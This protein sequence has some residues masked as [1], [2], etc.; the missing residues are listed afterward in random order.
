MKILMMKRN[1]IQKTILITI[2]FS[3]AAAEGFSQLKKDPL[4]EDQSPLHLALGIS[5]NEVRKSKEDSTYISHKLYYRTASG[6]NDSIKIDIKGRGNF[7]LRECDFPPLW[8]KIKS[9]QAKGTVFQGNKKLKLVLPCN[10]Q[11]GNNELIAKEWLCYKLYEAIT[12]HTFRTRLVNVDLTE[13]RRKKENTYQLKG[14]LIEDIDKIAKRMDGKPVEATRVDA[15]GLQDTASFRFSLFQLM[16]SNTDWSEI[17]Q[18]N[19]KLIQNHSGYI[20]VPYDFDMSGLVDAPYS[21]VSVIGDTQLPIESVRERYFRG[22]CRSTE[23]MQYVRNEFLTKE[24]K[25]LS[26]PDLLKNELPARDVTDIKNYLEDFFTILK[27]NDSFDD[28]VNKRCRI[29]E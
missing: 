21:V 8:I 9:S 7:R 1:N 16:I 5:I 22:Y 26:L 18:H 27:S 24:K 12:D 19:N 6:V 11:R 14:I 20:P 25:I 13:K 3:L 23:V 28:H 4:F 29:L 2:L 17:F 10:D 15:K